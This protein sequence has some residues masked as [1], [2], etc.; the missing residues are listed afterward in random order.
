MVWETTHIYL[1]IMHTFEVGLYTHG[2]FKSPPFKKTIPAFCV[3][4]CVTNITVWHVERASF[5]KSGDKSEWNGD[6][7]S[8]EKNYLCSRDAERMPGLPHNWHSRAMKANTCMWHV[9][10]CIQKPKYVSMKQSPDKSASLLSE[11]FANISVVRT[12][13]KVC[14]KIIFLK[15][16]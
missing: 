2:K 12:L 14:F 8:L 1:N 9:C 16:S 10:L 11:R 3:L 15:C 13:N 6:K 4:K 5:R 7:G